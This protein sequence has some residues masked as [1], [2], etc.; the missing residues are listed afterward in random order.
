[1][2]FSQSNGNGS[3]TNG[4]FPH[5]HRVNGLPLRLILDC[6]L[7][8]LSPASLASATKVYTALQSSGNGRVFPA[9]L[10]SSFQAAK[11][12]D[13]VLGRCSAAQIFQD[14]A[15]SFEVAGGN[16]VVT[17]Q[18]FETYCVNLRATLGSEEL[19]QLVLRD[20]FNF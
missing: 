20:C 2:N 13:V 4:R 6:L 16:G 17:F 15:L 18:H 12:P 9:A 7:E 11:H 14:F 19:L 5:E 10:A 8:R 3:T 1:S